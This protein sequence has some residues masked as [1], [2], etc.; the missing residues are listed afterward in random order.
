MLHPGGG[1]GAIPSFV[2]LEDPDS[3]RSDDDNPHE[4]KNPKN[5]G[6]VIPK[7]PWGKKTRRKDLQR[8]VAEGSMSITQITENPLEKKETIYLPFKSCKKHC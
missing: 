3:P 1:Q 7:K 6:P 2:A 5:P 8:C 4:K